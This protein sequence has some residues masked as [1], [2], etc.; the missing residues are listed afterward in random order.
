MR[1]RS[2]IRLTPFAIDPLELRFVPATTAGLTIQAEAASVRTLGG[3]I[4]D[5]WVLN[6]DGYDGEYLNFASSGTYTVT[7]RA[8]GTGAAG[9]GPMMTLVYD[10]A[11]AGSSA[12]DAS[13]W[14]TY[15]F[16]FNA[17]AGVHELK[18][19]FINDFQT[20]TEDRNLYLDW[21][22]ID[23]PTGVATPALSSAQAWVSAVKAQ[24]DQ[25]LAQADSLIQLYRQSDAVLQIVDKNG[26]PIQGATVSINQTSH[27]FLFGANLFSYARFGTPEANALFNQRFAALFNYGTVPFYWNSLESTQG[28]PNYQLTDMMVNWATQNG[29]TLKGHP[30]L[31]NT[32]YST[33]A[34]AGT[35][36]PTTAQ[37]QQHVQNVMQRYAGKISTWDVVN[38]PVERPGYDVAAAYQWARAADPNARLSV[39]EYGEYI[40]GN[41]QFYDFLKSAGQSGMPYDIISLQGH[42]PETD[43]FS[44]GQVWQTLNQYG[45]LGKRIQISEFTPPSA[46]QAMT[47]GV[48]TGTWN[49]Q[50]QADYAA[51][52]YKTA[53]ANPNVEAISWWD[54]YDPA[55]EVNGGGLL[56]ANLNP[57][58]AYNALFDL[59]NRQWHTQVSTTTGSSGAINFRGFHGNYDVQVSFGALNYHGSYHLAKG[60]GNVWRVQLD[61][62]VGS[63]TASISGPGVLVRG[64]AGN[65]LLN[66]A[67]GSGGTYTFNIDWNGDGAV[68][69]TVRG[70]SGT[71]VQYAPLSSGANTIRV[72]AVDSIGRA[73][74]FTNNVFDVKTWALVDS[75]D[76][77]GT[78]DLIYGGTTGDDVYLVLNQGNMAAI[79]KMMDNGSWVYSLDIVEGVTGN[80]RVYGQGGND[81][82]HAGWLNG[83][84]VKLYGGAGNDVL[85][86]S[87]LNDSLDGGD[88]NDVL[89]G[90]AG[91]DNLLGGNGADVLIGGL[92][93]DILQGGVGS[94]LFITGQTTY[95]LDS[96][97]WYFVQANWSAPTAYQ[98]KVNNFSARGT[99]P[100]SYV[101]LPQA[102]LLNDA[103]VD[104]IV[105]GSDQDW[106]LYDFSQDVVNDLATDEVKTNLRT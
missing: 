89:T 3:A 66:A 21:F 64:Q 8:S 31:W 43:R 38:E 44:M 17:T 96:N 51:K 46:G 30:L 20:A 50:S 41:P 68:D 102:S 91:N 73:S 16:Q 15:T 23:A 79:Y 74:P 56:D 69:Q 101:F 86:G 70:P 90:V 19:G 99:Q 22:K 26:T 87:A 40:D 53:F 18:L 34:W 36:G 4:A 7:A 47:G 75:T 11:T 92:G 58:P 78:K 55:A 42:T 37:L 27:D 72:S 29:I 33:P 80:V 84:S 28:Q 85:V 100:M 61:A 104:Q 25:I 14:N 12:V 71:Q 57:K 98:T 82:L 59:I 88:G 97:F 94:D 24:E 9:L 49:A 67:G 83:K 105:G 48:W 62:V 10:G 13:K 45:Q 93:A 60:A 5:C 35:S 103:A 32:P 63:P 95:D 76:V 39:N 52:F 106:M 77:P 81:C 65:F 54:V 1:H 6:G 2:A